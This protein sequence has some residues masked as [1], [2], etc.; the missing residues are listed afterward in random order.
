MPPKVQAAPGQA[1]VP[2][3]AHAHAEAAPGSVAGAAPPSKRTKGPTSSTKKRIG[4]QHKWL[5][6]YALRITAVDAVSSDVLTLSCRLCEK[7]GREKVTLGEDGTPKSKR[8]RTTNIKHFKAPWRSDNI[9]HHV[10]DQHARRFAEYSALTDKQKEVFLEYTGPSHEDPSHGAAGAGVAGGGVVGADGG[11]FFDP[12]NGV[13]A[14]LAILPSGTHRKE[15]VVCLVDAP[16]VETIVGDLLLDVDSEYEELVHDQ[17]QALGIFARQSGVSRGDA[18]DVYVVSVP[19]KLEF[20]LC[21]RYVASGTSFRQCV[22]MIKEAQE[23]TP[24]GKIGSFSVAKVVS[25]VRYATAMNFQVLSSILKNTWAFSIILDG[26]NERQNSYLGVRLRVA[27]KEQ[28]M[29][30]HVMTLP[31]YDRHTRQY[32]Y[33]SLSKLLTSL[34]DGWERKLVGIVSDGTP[35]LTGRFSDVVAKLH[36]STSEGC[37]RVW[38][39]AHQVEMVVENLFQQVFDEAFVNNLTSVTGHLRR[40]DDLISAM[41]CVCPRFVDTS[42]VSMG[43]L[44]DWFTTKRVEVK[45]YFDTKQPSCAPPSKWWVFMAALKRFTDIINNTIGKIQGLTMQLG[46]QREIIDAMIA[47]LIEVGYVRGP[48]ENLFEARE[49]DLE[50]GQKFIFG[51]YYTTH[52]GAESL[53]EDLDP[54]VFELLE[55]L[56]AK[57]AHSYQ[58]LVASVAYIFGE[59][60]NELSKIVVERSQTYE[61]AMKLP[62]VLPHELVRLS[63]SDLNRML[64]TQQLRLFASYSK[65]ETTLIHSEHAQM[66]TAYI[67]DASFKAQIDLM[68]NAWSFAKAWA[69]IGEVYPRLLNFVGGL[70]AAFPES[71]MTTTSGSDFSVLGYERSEY[72]SSLVDFSLEGTLQCKQYPKLQEIASRMGF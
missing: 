38:S 59:S 4:F 35:S 12:T 16:I 10:R 69:S 43:R 32:L 9:A 29:D 37:Y 53:L 65:E 62:T 60:V 26:G 15:R 39:G 52:R 7:Y 46:Q 72:R 64:R 45:A 66:K 2:A 20:E 22:N 18:R 25:F 58:A 71:V 36:Q 23:K 11:E 47:E 61:A 31:I 55:L 51:Q 56:K 42:W 5:S 34:H 54:F 14:P 21:L 17:A 13:G 3:Q 28:I 6:K 67:R 8:R 48:Y 33:D 19:N 57:D 63:G 49:F 50:E 44:I 27:L 70:A 24:K 30:F 41:Q 68:T 40:Q 1:H